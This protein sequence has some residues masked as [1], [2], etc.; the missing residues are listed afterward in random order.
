MQ[1]VVVRRIESEPRIFDTDI[2]HDACPATPDKNASY[3]FLPSPL[4]RSV[5]RGFARLARRP[6]NWC[7]RP[8]R[9]APMVR[10]TCLNGGSSQDNHVGSYIRPHCRQR[11]RCRPLRCFPN[12]RYSMLHSL[13]FMS[14]VAVCQGNSCKRRSLSVSCITY[15]TEFLR[16]S[17]IGVLRKAWREFWRVRSAGVWLL[18]MVVILALLILCFAVGFLKL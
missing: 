15:L 1:F 12:F 9:S 10:S 3:K 7:F 8:P 17:A 6:C 16:E 18:A 11:N 2:V 5:P 14:T 13:Q 4:I